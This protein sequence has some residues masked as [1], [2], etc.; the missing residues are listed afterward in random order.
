MMEK[1][2]L[3]VAGMTCAACVRR[4]ENTIKKG[5]GVGEV[6]VN[7]ATESATIEFDGSSIGLDGLKNLVKTAGYEP[8]DI[9]DEDTG[10]DR[11]RKSE[12]YSRALRNFVSSAL[13]TAPVMLL[14]MRHMTPWGHGIPDSS[15]D[16]IMF[17]FTTQVMFWAGSQFI[18][19]A[20]KAA[21]RFTSDMNTLIFVGTQSAYAYSTVASFAPDAI[22]V[23]GETPPV[24]F[25]TA[26]MIIT[27]IL[28]GKYLEA[29]AKGRASEAIRKLMDLRPKTARIIRDGVELEIPVAQAR[30][31]DM[32]IIRPGESAPVDGVVT[33]GSTA[34]DESMITGESIPAEKT[35]GDKIIGGSINKTGS[36]IF[37][38]TSIGSRTVLSQIIR[39]VREAQGTKAPAQKMAD[40]ISSYFVPIVMIVAAATFFAWYW[41]GPEPAFTRALVSFVSVL[42]IACPCALGLATPTAI[43]V[44]TGKGAELGV[45][46]RNGEALEKSARIKVIALDKTGTI[47]KGEPSVTALATADGV[48]EREL[49]ALAAAVEKRSEHPLGM[50]IVKR[51]GEMKLAVDDVKD[52]RS[53]TGAGV[54][55]TVNGNKL[56]VGSMKIMEESGVDVSPLSK[57]SSEMSSRGASPLFVAKNGEAL[58]VIA[59]EDTIKPESVTAIRDFHNRGMTVVMI[60]GDNE[61]TAGTIGAQVGIDRV[62]ANVTPDRKVEAVDSLKSDGFGVAMAGDGIND[63]PALARADVGFAMGGGT[64]IAMEAG[65][66]VLMSGNLHGVITALELGRATL[67]V[68]RQNLFWAFAYN[69]IL[70]PVAAGALYPLWGFTLNPMLAA[71]A[72]AFSSVSVVSNSLRLKTFR[73]P[74]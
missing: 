21:K 52:F 39:L 18:T 9:V 58:G 34:V 66:I 47:T 61:K 64:D 33:E 24:Y 48:E 28:M 12:E 45:L 74:S 26:A 8:Y 15:A 70:I 23:A 38:A 42:I 72:M 25:E 14:S 20:V 49:V 59:V 29:R 1:I 73:L 6:S 51:A 30:V 67:R 41:F 44:G 2:E 3:G 55:G 71:A 17:I 60:T 63:A 10:A 68:I 56:L 27:L 69:V 53:F 16:I 11:L 35:A 19:G 7:L 40:T 50:A 36:V 46:I 43:M 37:K 31:G 32:V 5:P 13:L 57:A 4:V 54:S 62:L 65:D 22:S